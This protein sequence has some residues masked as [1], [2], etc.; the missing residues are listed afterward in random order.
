MEVESSDYLIVLVG[1]TGFEPATSC[2]RN[3]FNDIANLLKNSKWLNYFYFLCPLIIDIPRE[4][5]KIIVM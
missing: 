3:V 5:R 1:T 4:R 2:S